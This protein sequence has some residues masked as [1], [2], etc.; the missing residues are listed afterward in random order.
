[1]IEGPEHICIYPLC[2]DA[3]KPGKAYCPK[4]FRQSTKVAEDRLILRHK[5][6]DLS[7]Y[8]AL[9]VVYSDTS[10]NHGCKK[11]LCTE[12][13]RLIQ[14]SDPVSRLDDLQAGSV[15]NLRIADAVL[16]PAPMLRILAHRAVKDVATKMDLTRRDRPFGMRADWWPVPRFQMVH[17]LRQRRREAEQG[18]YLGLALTYTQA[19]GIDIDLRDAKQARLADLLGVLQTY[20]FKLGDDDLA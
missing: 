4:H 2:P 20:G 6:F 7:E 17:A 9:A 15:W 19:K 5:R 13:V 10:G 8:Q 3:K 11:T 12:H 14:S 16:G 1:M 18:G